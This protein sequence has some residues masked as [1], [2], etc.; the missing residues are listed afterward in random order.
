LK[1]SATIVAVGTRCTTLR[2]SP[3]FAFR[4]G[5]HCLHWINSAA[6]PLGG[7]D[8]SLDVSVTAGGELIVR[9]IAAQLVY[10]GPHG[11]SSSARLTAEVAVGAS[12][13]W[14]PA[15]TVVV[16]G[17]D[18]RTSTTLTLSSDARLAWR[19]IVVLGR[20]DEPGGSLHQ[21]LRVT[22]AGRVLLH[23]ELALGPRWPG[24]SGPAGTAGARVVAS[25]LVVG[26]PSPHLCTTDVRAAIHPLA[27]DAWLV[28]ALAD[29]VEPVD[30]LF[31]SLL[32]A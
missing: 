31:R 14:E 6:G 19:E 25:A 12:L 5:A 29:A 17:A 9:G 16:D 32:G 13:R 26:A 8:L 23:T 28:T 20:H 21:R 1:S 24:S 18:H 10:P 22:R 3:P 11:L 7:D 30:A 2:A 27:H 15:P 4:Q